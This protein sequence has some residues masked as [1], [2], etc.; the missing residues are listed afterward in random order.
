M[1][2]EEVEIFLID[3]IMRRGERDWGGGRRGVESF[4][5]V[6][7]LYFGGKDGREKVKVRIYL[8]E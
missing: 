4:V 1:G 8:E 2:G 5:F 6:V 7:S 3:V